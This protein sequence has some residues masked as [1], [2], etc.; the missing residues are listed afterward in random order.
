MKEM[1]ASEL[2]DL[3]TKLIEE[4]GDL[5]VKT[6]RQG[7]GNWDAGPVLPYDATDNDPTDTSPA[8]HIYIH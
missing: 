4:H 8:T 6:P 3:L 7:G 1:R 2:I 5:P